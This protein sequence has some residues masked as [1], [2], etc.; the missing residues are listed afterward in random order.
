LETLKEHC[1]ILIPYNSEIYIS[2]STTPQTSSC[3]RGS[4]EMVVIGLLSASR[5]DSLPD[6]SSVNYKGN[7]YYN[8]ELTFSSDGSQ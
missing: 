4:I 3:S 2:A 6:I 8:S 1:C 7:V 5:Q